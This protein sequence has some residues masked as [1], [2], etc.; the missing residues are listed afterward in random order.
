MRRHR[1]VACAARGATDVDVL[2]A[3]YARAVPLHTDWG[4]LIAALQQETAGYRLITRFRA[5]SPWPWLPDGHP[6]L[7]GPRA[8]PPNDG[9]DIVPF[10]IAKTG[11]FSILR[12]V[13]PT[14]EVFRRTEP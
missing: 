9:R 13:N 7:V 6:D 5:S 1:H 12:D 3:D 8:V 2:S 14:I 10:D 11:V 4:E